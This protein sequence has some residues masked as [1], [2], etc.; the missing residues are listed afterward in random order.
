VPYVLQLDVYKFEIRLH[1]SGPFI[2]DEY[3]F[4]KITVCLKF[5][6][7]II[8]ATYLDIIYTRF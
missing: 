2:S 1:V 5:V 4:I 7:C 8:F 6:R 3:S